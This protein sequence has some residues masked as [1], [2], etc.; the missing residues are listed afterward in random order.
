LSYVPEP[1]GNGSGYAS[2]TF[3]VRDFAATLNQDPTPNTITLNVT[4]VSDPYAFSGFTSGTVIGEDAAQAGAI[5]DTGVSFVDIDGNFA[6]GR[7]TVTGLLAEDRISV[8]NQ[9]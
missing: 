9:G 1:N 2:F 5:I 4:P 7:L 8:L 6:G 3:Q